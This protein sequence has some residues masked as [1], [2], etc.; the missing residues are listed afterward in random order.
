MF[1][2][3]ARL[4][5]S[6]YYHSRG[7][8][9]HLDIPEAIQHV[10]Y[11]LADSLPREVLE[12]M[13]EGESGQDRDI[14]QA[15]AWRSRSD[16]QA[17]AWRSDWD[18]YLDAGYGSCILRE[19]MVA[20]MVQDSFL[21]FHGVRYR[22][23]AW[24][25]MPNH[26]HVLFQPLGEWTVAKVVASWKSFTGRRIGEFMRES[27]QAGDY[28][29]AGAWRSGSDGRAGAWRS[30]SSGQAGAWRSGS[31]GRAGAWRSGSSGQAG[32]WRSG[33]SDGQAGAWRSGRIWHREYWDRFIRDQR[34]FESG[35]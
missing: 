11:H 5:P 23:F 32:A 26:V 19:P 35:W 33:S 1:S 8:L 10:T 4:Q 31:D 21:K 28:C 16:G 30:G 29:Q 13:K 22:L 17:G 24:V 12:R 14:C 27:C 18:D 6:P 3:N 15:G 2:G 34:H 25:V 20:A 7:Y 9:P